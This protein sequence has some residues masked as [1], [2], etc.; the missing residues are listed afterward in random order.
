MDLLAVRTNSEQHGERIRHTADRFVLLLR[1][2]RGHVTVH[3]DLSENLGA[4]ADQDHQLRAGFEVTCQVVPDGMHI[5]DVLILA[6]GDRRPTNPFADR[7]PGV[8]G[9]PTGPGLQLDLFAVKH[10]EVHRSVRRTRG[11]D[12]VSGELQQFRTRGVVGE[13]GPEGSY[14]PVGVENGH[15]R[16]EEGGAHGGETHGQTHC[17]QD[18]NPSRPHSGPGSGGIPPRARI[19]LVPSLSAGSRHWP[20]ER[21]MISPI[22]ITANFSSLLYLARHHSGAEEELQEAAR[23]FLASRNDE[24]LLF[25][26]TPGWLAVNGRRLATGSPG[27]GELA[28]HMSSHH[29]AKCLV[30]PATTAAE[31]LRLARLLAAFPGTHATWDDT[32]AALGPAAG[33]IRLEQ[34]RQDLQVIH[35]VEVPSALQNPL[36]EARPVP[37]HMVEEGGLIP[38]AVHAPVIEPLQPRQRKPDSSAELLATL[39]AR[40]RAALEARDWGAVLDV[41]LE[42]IR[43]EDSA[44][45]GSASARLFRLELRRLL[46]RT[47]IGHLARLAAVGGRRD[48][49]IHVLRRLGA[50]ATEVLMDLLVEAEALAERRGYYSALMRMADGTDIIIHHLGHPQWY[51]VRNAAELC[52]EM[53]LRQA[54]PELG[55][56]CQHPDERVRKAIAGA[57]NR[58]GTAEALEPLARMFKDPSP[59]IRLQ[60]I[61]GLDGDRA[62]GLAMPLAATLQTEEHP[63]VVRESLRALGRIGTP[64]ALM[65]LRSVAQ[66]EVR[67]LAKRQRLQAVEA[68]A[69]AGDGARALLASLTADSDRELAA[70]AREALAVMPAA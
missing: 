22:S 26:A 21:P 16:R 30:E 49:A 51:V 19:L 47:E 28:E 46:S 34:G 48:D 5:P 63:D 9:R 68:L 55:R 11:L 52:G 27:A 12:P 1:E 17:M 61:G 4:T 65:A 13:T 31:V 39:G 14:D 67:H 42:Y 58:I 37:P 45:S 36:G 18:S 38:P 60:V 25:E 8:L 64:D 44:G 70:Q 3:V 20:R 33:N 53:G 66:G 54:V 7:Y 41:A 35:F 2:G 40:G 56:Q 24:R 6:G 23:V 32:L 29:I 59:A 43:G 10:V 50:D 15:G 69:L 62:R 57:L